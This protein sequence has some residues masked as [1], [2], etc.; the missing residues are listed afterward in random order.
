MP[1]ATKQ[2][3]TRLAGQPCVN[4]SCNRT[5]KP[6]NTQHLCFGCET[7]WRKN[8]VPV[9]GF[10]ASGDLKYITKQFLADL[11][12]TKADVAA[13]LRIMRGTR[14][15]EGPWSERPAYRLQPLLHGRWNQRLPH[16]LVGRRFEPSLKSLINA[17]VHWHLATQIIRTA[18]Q[19]SHYL[20]GATFYGRRAP[21]AP[22]GVEVLKG[23]MRTAGYRLSAVDFSAIGQRCLKAG[24][25]LGVHPE[26]R[27]I[28]D[29]IISLY[30]N[31]VEAGHCHRPVVLPYGTFATP[32][33]GDHPF[34]HM[35]SWAS[36][37]PPQYTDVVRRASGLI[38]GAWPE[39][40]DLSWEE[41]EHLRRQPRPHP[42]RI[43]T[44]D[45]TPDVAWIFNT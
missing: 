45:S 18:S 36:P 30:A 29:R 43:T 31:G 17:L 25:V 33:A 16:L 8:I 44:T 23:D 21:I 2:V 1:K 9:A 26:D 6:R 34:D 38:K 28:S 32:A 19:Y 40:L 12:S 3:T 20:A 5:I 4:P 41:R 35:Y 14:H 10:I 42:H 39:G 24:A 27:R 13:A 7:H 15:R 37:V 11:N 22:K